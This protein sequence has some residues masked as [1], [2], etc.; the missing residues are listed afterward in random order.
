MRASY[1]IFILQFIDDLHSRRAIETGEL[2]DVALANEI[3]LKNKCQNHKVTRFQRV[4]G[5]DVERAIDYALES[6]EFYA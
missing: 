2:G 4:V 3:V 1:K 6:E 5:Y